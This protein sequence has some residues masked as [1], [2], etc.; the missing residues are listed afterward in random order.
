MGRQ[1][2]EKFTR[3]GAIIHNIAAQVLIGAAK[4]QLLLRVRDGNLSCSIDPQHFTIEFGHVAGQCTKQRC[5]ILKEVQGETSPFTCEFDSSGGGLN[6]SDQGGRSRTKGDCC[7]ISKGRISESVDR[8]RA[9]Q[10]QGIMHIG[11]SRILRTI[12]IEG[13]TDVTKLFSNLLQGR[14]K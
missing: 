7:V 9:I 2:V 4:E 8:L 3:E 10:S 5:L 13:N 14:G 6:V 11:P 1:P 12:K